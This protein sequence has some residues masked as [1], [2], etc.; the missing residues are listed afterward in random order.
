MGDASASDRSG[1]ERGHLVEVALD[2]AELL[3]SDAHIPRPPAF[4]TA[5]AS[6]DVAVP[7]IPA[8]CSGMLHPTR[9]TNRLS[10]AIVS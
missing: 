10:P 7:L 1:G 3:P 5:A 2:D 6:A 9:S 8:C 4:E